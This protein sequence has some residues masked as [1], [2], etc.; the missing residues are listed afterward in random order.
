M[1]SESSLHLLQEMTL[2]TDL[3]S[4]LRTIGGLPEWEIYVAMHLPD[5][6]EDSSP[7]EHVVRT[8]LMRNAPQWNDDGQRQCFLRGL[9][10]PWVW[11]LE[12]MAVWARATGDK[13]GEPPQ[14]MC[15]CVA[16]II[17]FDQA[18]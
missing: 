15:S 6:F 5:D 14:Q 11:Y 4:Q 16:R 7:R 17:S 2:A 8:V 3:L 18:L 10:F 1:I 13:S 12:A 9:G